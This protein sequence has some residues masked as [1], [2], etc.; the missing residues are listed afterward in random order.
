MYFPCHLHRRRPVRGFSLVEL[1]AV[2]AITALLAGLLIPAVQSA[3]EASRRA[4]CA[5]NLR[6]IGLALNSYETVHR[7][8]TPGPLADRFGVVHNNYSE[9]AF[10]LPF[11]DQGPLFNS[12]NMDFHDLE[13]AAQ[14][15]LANR[16]VRNTRLL[17]YLCPSDGESNHLCSYRFN[18]GRYDQERYYMKPR[19]RSVFDGPFGL[20]VL[21]R[22]SA[23]TDGLSRTAFVSE[24]LGGDFIPGSGS[25]PR[26]IKVPDFEGHRSTTNDATLISLCLAAPVYGWDCTAGRYWLFGDFVNTGYNHNGAPND[27]RITCGPMIGPGRFWSASGGLDPPRSAHPGAVDVLFGDG[28]TE[29][30]SN[31]VDPSLWI[32]LGTYDFGDI[33]D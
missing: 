29:S 5:G 24:R 28:H 8:F 20:G 3:R 17:V 32:A 25:F 2:L 9:L 18:R 19:S 22:V 30:V 10:L 33:A 7:M 27:L 15:L 16:T 26:N 13:A 31:S 23:I 14:P 4:L 6:Q 12:L 11:I 1:I 21:P